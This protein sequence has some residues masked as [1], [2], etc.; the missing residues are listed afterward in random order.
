MTAA[1][2]YPPYVAY[3]TAEV[4]FLDPD[5]DWDMP[6]VVAGLRASG[7]DVD[8]PHWD[9]VTVDWSAYDL[10]VIRS[11]WNY[12]ARR[13]EF[14][15]W[16][17]SVASLT[18]LLNPAHVVADNTDKTYL[19]R[20]VA[21]GI[22]IIPT[23]VLAVGE[24]VDWSDAVFADAARIVVK[25]TIGAGA[26][27]A[28]LNDT[29][30]LAD[31]Q[32]AQHHAAGSAVLV[33]PYLDV[34]DTAGE[35]AIVVIDGEISHAVKKVPALSQGGHGDAMELAPVDDS[36]RE[37]VKGVAALVPEWNELLYARVDVVPDGA[38]SWLLMELELTEPTLF[39]GMQDGAADVLVAAMLDRLNY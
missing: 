33:Q 4:D 3:V 39:L 37:F 6:A 30:D 12:A 25:P 9:D 29:K 14:V 24:Q 35:V 11:T 15:A 19:A 21:A 20:L 2:E 26:I 36:M 38:G 18:T 32:I 27:G 10:V 16:A 13:D 22:P 7:V 17:K 28:S 34:V 1:A 31:G 8:T 5:P 23:Q